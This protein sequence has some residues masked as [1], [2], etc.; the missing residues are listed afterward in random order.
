MSAPSH[1][2]GPRPVSRAETAMAECLARIATGPR[3]SKDLDRQQTAAAMTAIL[4]GQ[5]SEVQAG[6]FLIALRMKRESH[7]EL[8]GVLDALGQH[9]LRAVADVDELVDIA[10]PYNGY[11]RHLPAAPFVPAVLAAC[12]V[13]CVLHGCREIGPKFGVTAHRVLATAGAPIDCD[14]RRCARAVEQVGWG[15]VDVRA[16]CPPLHNLARMRTLIVKRTCLSLLE[17]LLRPVGARR[18]NHLWIGY[19]HRE[20]PDILHQLARASGYDSMLA[21]RGV[22]GGVLTSLSGS[23]ALARFASAEP[24]QLQRA[25]VNPAGLVAHSE[26]RAPP[27]P[28]PQEPT[29]GPESSIPHGQ[30]VGVVLPPESLVDEWAQAAASA[31]LRALNGHSSPTADMLVLGAAAI[32]RALGKVEDLATG[33]ERARAALRSG[34]AKR[35]FEAFASLT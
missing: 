21:V 24:A 1:P 16:F 32:L 29:S 22:E 30:Q 35:R 7:E 14:S 13:P 5:V 17:K 18:R 34:E 4:A 31:G 33:A 8:C 11:V 19:T 9:T 28:T 2:P 3:L 12:G 26:V 15:Y 27:L 23:V 25:T 10:E 6:V 20:Y